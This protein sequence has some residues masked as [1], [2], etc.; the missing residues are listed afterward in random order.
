L[1]LA[2]FFNLCVAFADVPGEWD[3]AFL[4]VLYKGKGP[5]DDPNNYR[6]IT[7][8][9]Q[10]LKM[11]ESLLCSRLRTWAES[12][13]KLPEE[14]IAYRPGKVGTDHLF[15]LSVLRERNRRKRRPLFA[16]FVDLTKAFP[17]VNRQ[18]LLD[19]LSVIGVSDRFLRVISR[20]YSRDTFSLLL[21]GIPSEQVFTVSRGVH[22]GS[23]LSP[24]LFILYVSD[25]IV[26]LR[27]SGAEQGGLR[28]DDGTI[29][30]CII[31][32]DDIL[33]LAEN[34]EALQK[35]IDETTSYFEAEGMSVNPVKS[36]IVNFSAARV[37]SDASFTIAS[38]QKELL[39]Q[40]RYLGVLFENNF[41][42]KNQREAISLRCRVA[43]G[44]CNLICSSLGITN[45]HTMLQ[46]YDMFVSSIFR[47]S[48]GAWGPL[49]GNLDCIDDIFVQFIRKQF[50][51]PATTSKQGVLMQFGRRCASCDSYYLG[52]VQIARG[53]LHTESVWGRT[54]KNC[55]SQNRWVDTMRERL[56]DMGMLDEVFKTPALFLEQRKEKAVNFNQW[57][58][59]HHLVFANGTSADLLRLGRPYG[60]LPTVYS[61]PSFQ[62][63]KILV[64]LLSVWRWSLQGAEDYPEYCKACD[65]LIS[66]HHLLFDCVKT[67]DIRC[68]FFT[69]T[70]I[71]FDESV[72]YRDDVSEAVLKVFSAI[73]RIV[74]AA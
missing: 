16:A 54:L 5:V 73:C 20:L 11:L 19:K 70:G 17:S 44:R 67:G 34:P 8:K 45:L 41:S 6:G 1:A 33:L 15:S 59:H 58:H 49:A 46:I 12:N 32:A 62:S 24:L 69:E 35:L 4:H 53:L 38:V 14:Q 52:A 23:P 48:A 7:L 65:N 63:R 30:C 55:G 43:L 47:Y 25:L 72:L 40:A 10:M 36:E 71:V 18:R 31:Y 60:V 22:E 26:H 66:S 56:V 51:L 37:R 39:D 27:Q 50:R 57:C 74:Q 28:L 3:H 9:S 68:T 13:H 29:V 42:W 2:N 61:L 64:F 21:D